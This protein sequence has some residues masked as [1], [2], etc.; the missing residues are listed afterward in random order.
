MIGDAGSAWVSCRSHRAPTMVA[1]HYRAWQEYWGDAISSILHGVRTRPVPSHLPNVYAN[2][3]AGPWTF[4]GTSRWVMRHPGGGARGARGQRV[5]RAQRFY[6][7]VV[8]SL[9]ACGSV[10]APL[11]VLSG[12]AAID[13]YRKCMA[14]CHNLPHPFSCRPPD[15]FRRRNGSVP[16]TRT[17]P[18]VSAAEAK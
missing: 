11:N 14:F 18:A 3:G 8:R 5:P 10:V 7:R 15:A 17:A 4:H 2:S 1:V 12:D 9:C 6:G 13:R 16:P